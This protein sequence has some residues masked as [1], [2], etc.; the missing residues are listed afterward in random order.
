MPYTWDS[1]KALVRSNAGDLVP[2]ETTIPPALAEYV[3]WNVARDQTRDLTEASSM[4]ASW[5]SY[6]KRM[7]GYDFS[8]YDLATAKADTKALLSGN[9]Q[10]REGYV[11]AVADFIKAELEESEG[12]TMLRN[13]YVRRKLGLAGFVSGDGPEL[14]LE[15]AKKILSPI[16]GTYD[17]LI[18]AITLYVKGELARLV[19]RDTERYRSFN[20]DYNQLRFRLLG[21]STDDLGSPPSDAQVEDDVR[22]RLGTDASRLG[23]QDMINDL[24]RTARQQ[25]KDFYDTC[26]ALTTAAQGDLDH[27][28]SWMDDVIGRGIAELQALY[29]FVDNHIRQVVIDLQRYIPHYTIGHETI[30]G[31]DDVVADCY[32]SRGSLPEGAQAVQAY[33]LYED[34]DAPCDEC[35]ECEIIHDYGFFDYGH[36]ATTTDDCIPRLIIDP[37]GGLFIVKPQLST[38]KGITLRLHWDGKKLEFAGGDTVPF[39][40]GSVYAAA[41][42]VNAEVSREFG[43]SLG[44]FN[45]FNDSYLRTR[46]RL[47][48]SL[49]EREMLAR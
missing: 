27:Y 49:K 43:S 9:Q 37:K 29:V 12:T 19:E 20:S 15:D 5:K 25:I 8:V 36:T 26:L 2:D 7:L 47:F 31:Q 44:I 16:A 45:S 24:I 33:I 14:I 18:Q 39:D 13:T 41:A 22:D 6:K 42:W 40:E 46:R 21:F 34:A 23:A 28:G 32:A 4:L 38:E 30:Y 48:V 3:R 1:F 17:T 10:G 35:V 11:L